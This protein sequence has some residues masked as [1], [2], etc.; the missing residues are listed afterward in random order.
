LMRNIFQ[1]EAR[2]KTRYAPKTEGVPQ[3]GLKPW[4][5]VVTPHQ[6]VQSGN[7]QKAEFAADLAQVHRGDA[8]SEYQDPKEF[9]QRTHLTAGLSDLLTNALKRLGQNEGD[10][11]VELQ[12]SFGGGKTHSMLALYHMVGVKNPADL[13]GVDTLLDTVKLS[14]PSQKVHRAVL[15]GTALSPGQ[16]RTKSDGTKL[17]TLWGELAWQLGDSVGKGKEAYAMLAEAD[18][19]GVSPGSEELVALFKAYSPAIIL[20]D[21]WVAYIRHTY[22]TRNVLVG[23]SFETNTT[24]AQAL[25]E[26]VKSSP[27]TLLV[28]SL[29]SSKIEVG[30][31]GGEHALETLK[32]TFK[33]VQSSWRPA[34]AE[35]SY[36]II[37]RRLFEPLSGQ[38]F[39]HRDAVVD[40]FSKL[41]K[42]N[43]NEF[44]QGCKDAP[45]KHKLENCYPI[46]PELFE[47]L[48]ADWSTLPKFQQTRGVLRLMAS[49]IHALW[50]AG[51]KSL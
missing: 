23:G 37:R 29:P 2:N 19:S 30:G 44:P 33:R 9:F 35:E 38:D 28:A 50:E 40:A 11:V 42:D 8:S 1:E 25:T 12:T 4:R 31:E 51:D 48:Y 3:A 6:D 18:E 27:N 49:V 14:P 47:R 17:N 7:Y 22:N 21:E 36:E 34:N 32:H 41:Y 39:A 20:I 26:A 45:Y 13:P 5:E 10:P 16:S 15:V 43:A 46:H 24:F